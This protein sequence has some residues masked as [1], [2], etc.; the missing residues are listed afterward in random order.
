[1]KTVEIRVEDYLYAF[2]EK[3]GK[4]VGLPAEQVMADALFRMAGQ[5]ACGELE[6]KRKV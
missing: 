4:A 6:K 3:V 5:L 2:Y 1:M